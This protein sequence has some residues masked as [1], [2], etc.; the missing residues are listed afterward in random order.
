MNS[1][2]IEQV[3][4]AAELYDAPATLFTATFIG[5]SNLFAGTVMAREAGMVRIALATGDEAMVR[6]SGAPFAPGEA[7]LCMVRPEHLH[8][9]EAEDDASGDNRVRAVLDHVGHL[10]RFAEASGHLDDGSA[11]LVQ[12]SPRDA[13]ALKT[14]STIT[15]RFAAEDAIAFSRSQAA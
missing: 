9:I 1:G 2:R 7:A 13:A 14:R 3:S 8:V 11:V 12:L 10:G 5:R 6:N 4:T 15:L